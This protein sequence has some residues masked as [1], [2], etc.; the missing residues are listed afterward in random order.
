MWRKKIELD[1]TMHLLQQQLGLLVKD[2][3]TISGQV[4]G[5]ILWGIRDLA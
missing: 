4:L 2:S 1:S 3:I 5:P